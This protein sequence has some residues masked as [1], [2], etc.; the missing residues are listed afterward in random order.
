MKKLFFIALLS[1]PLFIYSQNKF[2]ISVS[3]SNQG[4]IDKV[5]EDFYSLNFPYGFAIQEYTNKVKGYNLKYNLGMSYVIRDSFNIRLRM[6][7]A[8]RISSYEQNYPAMLWLNSDNQKSFELSPSFGIIRHKGKF[9]F[10]TGIEIPVFY[11][12]DYTQY[13]NNKSYDTSLQLTGEYEVTTKIDGG[14]IF[15]INSYLNL[16]FILTKKIS[17]FS[18]INFGLMFA[19]LGGMYERTNRQ[20][21]PNSE[22]FYQSFEKKYTKFFVS[23]PQLQL[24]VCYQF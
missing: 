17:L 23:P 16:K 14:L 22:K 24:G 1:F 12:D 4:Q 15:G 7:F 8:S 5:V 18:E 19:K 21:L 10:N 13:S 11:I 20:I 6:G 2:G 3:V 9:S